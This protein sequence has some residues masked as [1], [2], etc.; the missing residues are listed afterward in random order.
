[1]SGHPA[2]CP[3]SLS[4]GIVSITHR[5]RNA[6]F[7]GTRWQRR[8]GRTMT[9]SRRQLFRLSGAGVAAASLS[10]PS[11]GAA[12]A[13]SPLSPSPPNNLLH[14]VQELDTSG[15]R[16]IARCDL[17]ETL[18]LATPQLAQDIAG[19]PAHMNGGDS[20]VALIVYRHQPSGFVE[21]QRLPVSGGEDAEFFGIG[22]RAFLAT[23]SIRSG[24]GPYSYNVDSTIFEWR[25]G[26]FAR[27][28]SI[29]T[30][31]AKQWR[32]FPI[33]EG[34]FL[35]PGRGGF[36]VPLVGTNHSHSP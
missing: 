27:F 10:L 31:A 11:I 8:R 20:D 4:F 34:G 1:M 35:S 26:R 21:Y 15:A 17:D 36:V 18:Y 24:H 28:Q 14:P 32:H 6:Y 12:E 29:P 33:G 16:G 13:A 3:H 2:S 22:G 7:P 23:A 30:F 19:Q 5:H 9:M 25:E